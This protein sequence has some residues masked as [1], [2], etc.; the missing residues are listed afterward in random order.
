M[1]HT[2]AIRNP[3][4]AIQPR[5]KSAIGN[6]Q[7]AVSSRQQSAILL[8]AFAAL[9]VSGCAGWQLGNRSLYRQDIRT[10]YVPPVDSG[11]FRRNLGERLTEALVRELENKSSFK[12]VADPDADS[13]LRCSIITDSK[14]VI[15]ETRFDD[16]RDL[17]ANFFVQVSWTDRHGNLIGGQPTNVP[18]PFE[19]RENIGESANFVPEGGQSLATAQQEAFGR[20]AQQIVGMMEA[21]W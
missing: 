2:S 8:V 15:N 18:L 6:Q 1:S 14:M 4:S 5:P 3:Q 9:L 10:V 17:D 20:L 21:P 7:S 16:P 13:T 12:V 11:S 19:I